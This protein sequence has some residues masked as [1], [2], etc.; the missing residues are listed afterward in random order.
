[1]NTNFYLTWH[2]VKKDLRQMAPAV[3]AWLALVVAS[4]LVVR[5][6]EMPVEV[7]MG[8]EVKSWLNGMRMV[9]GSLA[10][11]G[12]VLGV[13]LMAQ[14]VQEDALMGTEAT[15]R[16]RPIGRGRLLAAKL[17]GAVVMFILAPVVVLLPIWLASGFST[18]ELAEA[19]GSVA[20]AQ[21]AM[22][23]LAGSV[24]AMT[25][26][27]GYFVF[28]LVGLTLLMAVRMIFPRESAV[29]ADVLESRLVI[30]S[31]FSVGVVVAAGGFQYFTGRTRWAW[32]MMVGGLVAVVVASVVWP[33]GTFAGL[34]GVTSRWPV[35]HEGAAHSLRVEKIGGSAEPSATKM[36]YLQTGPVAAADEFVVPWTGSVSRVR[37]TVRG[38]IE[39]GRRWGE[40]AAKRV[41]GLVPNSGPLTTVMEVRQV[42]PADMGSFDTGGVM[43]VGVRLA[44]VKARLVGE[45][46]WRAG[47]SGWSGSSFTRVVHVEQQRG[48]TSG[49]VKIEER[50]ALREG[51]LTLWSPS[52]GDGAEQRDCFVLVNRRLGIFQTMRVVENGSMKSQGLM[53]AERT[54]EYDVPA[55]SSAGWA[56]DAVIVKVR[57]EVVERW[58][59]SLTG[60]VVVVV[61][62]DK[63]L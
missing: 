31:I 59:T 12:G 52:R 56:R 60:E 15:W 18:A 44:R 5:L 13:L 22:I 14:L 4:A 63:N 9:V 58:T 50:D 53:L 40:A 25:R 61:E 7:A 35:S 34:P 47:A 32:T 39:P 8:G 27:L 57:F 55:G 11:A 19:V 26:D 1:M 43:T 2:I 29:A 23:V 37:L 54:L 6:V 28:G 46:P 41:L 51:L 36:I 24:A 42:T 16:T 21:G 62:E 33:W 30:I 17:L 48:A 49:E 38:A 3:G 45:W 10:G 20:A